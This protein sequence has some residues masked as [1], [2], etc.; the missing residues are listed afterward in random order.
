[1]RVAHATAIA[2]FFPCSSGFSF[3]FWVCF[4]FQLLSA[5]V[6]GVSRGF[7]VCGC[8]FGGLFGVSSGFWEVCWVWVLSG[9]VWV[10]DGGFNFFWDLGFTWILVLVVLSGWEGLTGRFVVFEFWV[11]KSSIV[12]CLCT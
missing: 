12:Y 5:R 10:F 3:V 9:Q 8:F 7:W 11:C 4:L 1:V 2:F 6:L